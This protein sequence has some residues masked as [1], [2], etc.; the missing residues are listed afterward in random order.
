MNCLI[1]K[2]NFEFKLISNLMNSQ[3]KKYEVKENFKDKIVIKSKIVDNFV[4]PNKEADITSKFYKIYYEDNKIIQAQYEND[5][6]YAVLTYQDNYCL[7]EMLPGDIGRKEYL[8]T[9]YAGVY[10]ILKKQE[11]ILIHSSSFA[12]KDK[13]VLVI[14]KSGTGKSTHVRLWNQYEDIIQINDDK[15]II[16]LEDDKLMI[17]GNP[18]SGKSFIDQNIKK[19]LTDLVFIYQNKENVI[20]NISKKEQMLLLL[21]Q[22]TNSSF[23]YD[24]TKWN[25]LTN[26]LL[27]INGKYLGCNISQEAVETLKKEL[28]K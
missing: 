6:L 27:L 9:E 24:K 22:I 28:E 5:N 10:Y 3:L 14:A 11:G 16:I 23:M 18:W 26:H 12:Y 2:T 7:I 15:N 17:Y 20:R 21:P 19:E 8:L 13:G 4:L 1:A 25:N